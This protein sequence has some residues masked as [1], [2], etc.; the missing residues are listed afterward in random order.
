MINV[1]ST[2]DE[3]FKDYIFDD[4]ERVIKNLSQ[5]NIFIGENNSGKSRF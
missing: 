4:E 5:V 3:L 1:I 2:Q